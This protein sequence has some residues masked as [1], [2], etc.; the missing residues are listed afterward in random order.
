VPLD[1]FEAAF[2]A[3]IMLAL[4]NFLRVISV[5]LG[6]LRRGG[7]WRR[8]ALCLVLLDCL[9]SAGE[10]TVALT[11]EHEHAPRRW[12][13]LKPHTLQQLDL[14][15][16][17]SVVALPWEAGFAQ[18]LQTVRSPLDVDPISQFGVL[19]GVHAHW[20]ARVSKLRGKPLQCREVAPPS[21]KDDL[22]GRPV[23]NFSRWAFVAC[24]SATDPREPGHCLEHPNLFCVDTAAPFGSFA[25]GPKLLQPVRT[26]LVR[27]PIAE[28]GIGFC[29]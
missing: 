5:R 28:L 8:L 15:G 13:P 2:E 18:M 10:P 6:F 7:P 21:R 16:I 22:W 3:T 11:L 1:H 26:A 25:L 17:D 9:E 27:N 12:G 19:F 23:A 29:I 4:E 24:L 14:F 20:H